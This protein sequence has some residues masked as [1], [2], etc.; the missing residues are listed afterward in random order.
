MITGF[1][2]NAAKSVP[3][4]RNLVSTSDI[5]KEFA[6]TYVR[7]GQEKAT[8]LSL[9]PL[10]TRT[11]RAEGDRPVRGEE[12]KPEAKAELSGFG[13]EVQELTPTLAKQFGSVVR[14]IAKLALPDRKNRSRPVDSKQQQAELPVAA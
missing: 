8:K 3:S 7:E 13:L 5:G 2:G 4:F 9:V 1:N 6:L 14:K 11:M 12:P 10:D